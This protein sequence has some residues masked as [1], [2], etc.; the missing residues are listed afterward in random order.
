MPEGDDHRP[1]NAKHGGHRLT[2]ICLTLP[3]LVQGRGGLHMSK[4]FELVQVFTSSVARKM[5]DLKVSLRGRD[6]KF[7]QK[8]P[9]P[10][11]VQAP[12]TPKAAKSCD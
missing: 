12:T 2:I 4:P 3:V 7:C 9:P 5:G 6:Q 8:D 11:Q 1:I 10:P